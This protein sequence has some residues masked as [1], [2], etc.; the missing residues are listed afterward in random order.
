MLGLWLYGSLRCHYSSVPTGGPHWRRVH[1]HLKPFVRIG[2]AFASPPFFLASTPLMLGR[3]ILCHSSGFVAS[4]PRNWILSGTSVVV[5]GWEK[6]CKR[7]HYPNIRCPLLLKLLSLHN[8]V[9]LESEAR[10]PIARSS[11][12]LPQTKEVCVDHSEPHLTPCLPQLGLVPFHLI[13]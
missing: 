8:V 9:L 4:T 11:S 2:S 6:W 12:S 5:P 1:L 13:T 3:A 10:W 7:Q